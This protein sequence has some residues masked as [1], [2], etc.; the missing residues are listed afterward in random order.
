MGRRV[1]D[2]SI[3]VNRTCMTKEV[4]ELVLALMGDAD[5]D[6]VNKIMIKDHWELK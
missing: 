5:A 4:K 2:P 1:L 6:T 3:Q